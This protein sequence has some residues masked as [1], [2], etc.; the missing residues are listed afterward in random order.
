M[1]RYLWDMHHTPLSVTGGRVGGA[2]Y[3]SAAVAYNTPPTITSIWASPGR[4]TFKLTA[5]GQ[6]YTQ[7][8]TLKLDP[9]VKTLALQQQSTASRQLYDETLAVQKALADVR[10]LR[11]QIREIKVPGAAVEAGRIRQASRGYRR[12]RRRRA[13]RTRW[14]GRRTRRD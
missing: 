11:A 5:N 7:P 8:L 10:A 4:Y 6:S 1:H 14:W 3:S 13:W 2:T 9:R 12:W